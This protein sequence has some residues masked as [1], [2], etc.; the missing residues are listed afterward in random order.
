[1]DSFHANEPFDRRDFMQIG[2]LI[3]FF[4][5][6]GFLIG[7]ISDKWAFDRRGFMQMSLLIEIS[8]K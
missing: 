7:E 3:H 1:M 2:F 6:I 4:R 8:R 5:Q